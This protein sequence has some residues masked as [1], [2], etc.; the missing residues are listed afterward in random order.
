MIMVEE[1]ILFINSIPTLLVI[2]EQVVLRDYD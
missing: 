2:G 1:P